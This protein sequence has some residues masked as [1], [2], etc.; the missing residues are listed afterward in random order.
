MLKVKNRLLASYLLAIVALAG[1]FGAVVYWL[2][3]RQ[4]RSLDLA[5]ADIADRLYTL[6][7][8]TALAFLVCILVAAVLSRDRKS[9][10]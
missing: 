2:A 5:P 6:R 7:L 9:V 1:A 4:V 10:V 3:D 8:G